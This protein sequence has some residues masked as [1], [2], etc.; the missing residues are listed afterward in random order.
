MWWCKDPEQMMRALHL[1]KQTEG[2]NT[3]HHQLFLKVHKDLLDFK[4]FEKY[5]KNQILSPEQ[6]WITCPKQ[7]KTSL[8]R[9]PPCWPTSLTSTSEQRCELLQLTLQD[10]QRIV[11]GF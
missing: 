5:F 2:E 9:P 10:L 4:M 1:D 11:R 8:P 6:V 7:Q 3:L